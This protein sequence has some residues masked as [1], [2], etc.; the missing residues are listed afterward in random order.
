M[1]NLSDRR[2]RYANGGRSMSDNRECTVFLGVHVAENVLSK[3]FNDVEVMPYKNPGYDFI[4]NKGKKIDAKSSCTRVRD[5]R[6]N[7]WAFG[8][9][10]NKIAD[11]FLCLAL[12]NREDLTPL[13][14][15]LIP[16]D[17][18]NNNV[19]VSIS[20]SVID[21]WDKYKLDIGNVTACC[22]EMRSHNES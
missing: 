15:W 20:E 16:S 17:E 11:Y 6:S 5:G 12:D 2:R 9:K 21:K 7:S 8:I 14:I 10:K 19:K 13:H 22:N 18:V 4:C 1:K 3:M